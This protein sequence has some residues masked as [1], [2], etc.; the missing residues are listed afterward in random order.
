MNPVKIARVCDWPTLHS[1][2]DMQVFLGFTNFY[3]QF[4]CSFSDIA[5]PLFNV[6]GSNTAWSWR[7]KQQHAFDVLKTTITTATVLAS[8]DTSI[9]FRVKVDSLNFA[10]G[11]LSQQFNEDDKWH[12]VMF[13]SKSLSAVEYNYKIHNKKMLVVIQALEEWRHFLED[14]KTLVEI[15]TDH[16]NLEY[17][18][19]AKKLNCR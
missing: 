5:C 10:T 7:H 18:M 13:F 9:L 4:I 12:L 1:Y 2:I 14:V 19:M 6:S 16:K 8:S 17:F 15:W 11:V 3:H